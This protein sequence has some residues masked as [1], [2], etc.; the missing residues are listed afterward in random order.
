MHYFLFR[1]ADSLGRP[2]WRLDKIQSDDRL[3]ARAVIEQ[4]Y[5]STVL[6]LWRLPIL[7]ST[8]V[9]LFLRLLR[10][11][12]P[13]VVLA[14]FLHNL[15]VM[16]RCGLPIDTALLELRDEHRRDGLARVIDDL[17][18]GVGA[19]KTLSAVLEQHQ[20]VVP[21]TVLALIRVGEQSGHLDQVLID[22]SVHLNRMRV[23]QQ[24]V[25][26]ALIYPVFVIAVVLLAAYFWID[27]VLPNIQQ[28]F[29]QMNAHLPPLTLWAMAAAD[30]LRNVV[31]SYFW[32]LLGG[33]VLTVMVMRRSVWVKHH[34]FRVLYYLPI[35]SILVRSSSLAFI[36]EY[37]SLLIRAGVTLSEALR[38]LEQALT[39]PFYRR[40]IEQMRRG[41]QNGNPLSE[42]MQASGVFPRLIVRLV[43]VGEQ[44]GNLDEQL[45]YLAAE[46]RRRLQHTVESLAEILKPAVILVAGV[47]FIFVVVVFL[48]P[49]YQLIGQ[50]TVY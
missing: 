8:V 3:V 46:Y 35:S 31:R 34:L 43:S 27:Y 42:E 44:S 5:T 20:D 13:N 9:E 47:F 23:I 16:L 28:M 21:T 37:L 1:Y 19:G 25:R 24:D 2:G 49:V 33:G 14:E 18:V 12:V 36:T 6:S 4:R 45:G 50:T 10:R 22:G 7:I 15:G 17:Y 38:V 30:T 48:L 32:W 29:M 40:R 39:N 41:I 11:P 26:K